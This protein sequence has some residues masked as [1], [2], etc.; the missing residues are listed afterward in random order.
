MAK[1]TMSMIIRTNFKINTKIGLM[2]MFEKED[3]TKILIKRSIILSLVL[4]G[5][6][7]IF[8]R[9]RSLEYI[10]GLYLGT[11]VSIFSFKQ[12]ERTV[13]RAVFMSPGKARSYS[14]KNYMFR[15]LI[16]FLVLLV[17]I[18][19]K[20]LNFLATFLGFTMIKMVIVISAFI[21]QFKSN[22]NS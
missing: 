13:N 4:S 12:M 7:F 3:M 10:L 16:Y 15:Y 18:K 17:T 8:L 2:R 6:L 5:V 19:I 14:M 21:D 11:L 9:S 1:K 22:D 20:Y